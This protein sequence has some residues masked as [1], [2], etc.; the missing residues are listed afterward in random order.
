MRFIFIC[1]SVLTCL[2]AGCGLLA[3][4]DDTTYKT[5]TSLKGETKVFMDDCASRGA[6]GGKALS[7]L[8]GLRVKLSQAYEYEAGKKANADTAENVK[9]LASLV[10]EV[11]MNFSRGT[12]VE[13]SCTQRQANEPADHSTGCLTSGYCTGKVK[14]IEAGFDIVISTEP[15]KNK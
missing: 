12:L 2:L 6:S 15:L 10:D 13:G 5:M 9:E 11:Y 14:S 3:R 4:Y 7:T 8:E 1:I